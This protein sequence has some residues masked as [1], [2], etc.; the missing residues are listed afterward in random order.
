M[1]CH[2]WLCFCAL[3]FLTYFWWSRWS[4]FSCNYV[5]KGIQ[6]LISPKTSY[7]RTIIQLLHKYMF[8]VLFHDKTA[9]L[10]AYKDFCRLVANCFQA[11][12]SR[13]CET[14]FTSWM[15]VCMCYYI[16]VRSSKVSNWGIQRSILLKNQKLFQEAGFLAM[17]R[18]KMRKRLFV[19]K[20]KTL[21]EGHKNLK[22]ISHMFWDYW[23]KTSVLSKQ[24]VGDFFKFCVAFS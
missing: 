22:K 11:L 9:Y 10:L 15:I 18:K 4:D 21:W 3:I 16:L 13:K 19:S 1:G 2:K 14:P 7:F 8:I 12:T 24:V 23:L 5:K 6:E 20:V 17:R